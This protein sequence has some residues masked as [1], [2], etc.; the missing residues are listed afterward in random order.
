MARD[1]KRQFDMLC[2]ELDRAIGDLGLPTEKRTLK[3]DEQA[4]YTITAEDGTVLNV[5]VV[6][7]A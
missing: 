1:E 3:E 7:V 2:G 6:V 4:T 5:T